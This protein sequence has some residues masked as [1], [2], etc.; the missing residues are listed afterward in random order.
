MFIKKVPKDLEA[1]FLRK[2]LAQFGKISS[3]KLKENRAFPTKIVYVAYVK[4]IHAKK[5]LES[6][7]LGKVKGL[8]DVSVDFF[9]SKQ[10]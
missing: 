3:I 1:D 8:E 6:L 9:V 4:P 5:A 7:N 10:E 2:I